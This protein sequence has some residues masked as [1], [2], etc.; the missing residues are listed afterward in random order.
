MAWIG[1]FSGPYTWG[2]DAPKVRIRP[3]RGKGRG[4]TKPPLR[5]HRSKRR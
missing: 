5:K 4:V 1:W 3:G 2:P